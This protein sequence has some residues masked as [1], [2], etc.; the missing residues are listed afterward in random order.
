MP[1]DDKE[2]EHEHAASINTDRRDQKGWFLA[3][4][5]SAFIHFF[6]LHDIVNNNN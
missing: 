3:K 4:V 2:E 5:D 1:S 6:F